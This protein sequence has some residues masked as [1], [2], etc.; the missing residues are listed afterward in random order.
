MHAEVREGWF[1]RWESGGRRKKGKAREGGRADSSAGLVDD[2]R[3]GCEKD[4]QPGT[5]KIY[6]EPGREQKVRARSVRGEE[7]GEGR[8]RALADLV[9]R[10]RENEDLCIQRE[11]N[12]RHANARKR[13]KCRFERWYNGKVGKK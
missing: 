13:I 12:G 3:E 4:F 9:R 11:N 5:K 2:E 8:R 10:R 6:Q 7:D 1:E